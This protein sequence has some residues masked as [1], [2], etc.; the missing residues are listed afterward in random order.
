MNIYRIQSAALRAKGEK[1]ES[2]FRDSA[3]TRLDEVRKTED[4]NARLLTIPVQR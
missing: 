3:Q 2:A 1:F 4:P